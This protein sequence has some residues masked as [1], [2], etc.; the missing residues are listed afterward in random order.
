MSTSTDDDPTLPG[1]RQRRLH[2]IEGMSVRILE[3]GFETPGRPLVLLLHGFPELAWSWR[4][5]MPALAQA[6]FHVVAPDQRGYGGTTGWDAHADPATFRTHALA[7]DALRIVS[8]LG[9]RSAAV[10]GHDVGAMVAA[11]AAL[12]RPDVFRFL[13]MVSFPFDGPP[14][15]PST[16]PTMRPTCPAHRS[17]K[18]SPRCRARARTAWRSSPRPRPKTTCFIRRRACTPSCAPIST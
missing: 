12:V 11:Y 10:V 2:D 6:G 3:A 17:R 9:Y 16:M 13:T 14:A 15:L 18:S 1:L 8:A 5:V 7:L 4:K